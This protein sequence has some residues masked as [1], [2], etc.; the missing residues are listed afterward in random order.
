MAALETCRDQLGPDLRQEV[1]RRP[2]QVDALA[3]RDLGVKSV[4]PGNLAQDDELLRGDL[5]TGYARDHRVQTSALEIGQEAVVRVLE[6]RVGLVEDALVPEA[7]QDRGDGRLADLAALPLT[8]RGDQLIERPDFLDLRD[9]IEFLAAVR[10]VLAEPIVDAG[11]RR[12]E[13]PP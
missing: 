7:C 9:L 2:E 10:E 1:D 8:V 12:L 11:A 13:A 3:S 6:R 4:L 5:A